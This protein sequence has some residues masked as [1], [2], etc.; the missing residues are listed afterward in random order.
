ME[1]FSALCVWGGGGGFMF[2]G[3]YKKWFHAGCLGHCWLGLVKEKE[4]VKV[5]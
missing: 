2:G 1:G 3:A 4:I 5:N